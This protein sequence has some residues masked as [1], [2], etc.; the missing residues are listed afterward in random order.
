[1]AGFHGWVLAS[2]LY[3]LYGPAHGRCGTPEVL[4]LT[5][6]AVVVAPIAILLAFAIGRFRGAIADQTV[7]RVIALLAI[8]ALLAAVVGNWLAFLRLVVL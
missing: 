7:W 3:R 6:G 2:V 8:V 5:G 1:L 4:T